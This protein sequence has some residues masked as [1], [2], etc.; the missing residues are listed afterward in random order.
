MIDH[1]A[2]LANI[3]DET[4]SR[5]ALAAMMED[6]QDFDDHLHDHDHDHDHGHVM[7]TIMTTIMTM[8]IT[9]MITIIT[10]ATIRTRSGN[11]FLRA[12]VFCRLRSGQS[13]FQR[14]ICHLGWVEPHSAR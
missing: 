1:I 7:T 9:P 10:K 8:T 4:T 13:H 11:S 14:R 2:G 5:E 6:D 12:Q 3:K